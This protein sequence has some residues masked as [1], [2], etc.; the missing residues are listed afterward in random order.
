MCSKMYSMLRQT[1]G[2]SDNVGNH[3]GSLEAVLNVSRVL[4]RLEISKLLSK[5][6][7]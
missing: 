2:G 7:Q 3:I 4:A 1:C 5:R 6:G